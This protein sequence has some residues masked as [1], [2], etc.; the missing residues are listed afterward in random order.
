MHGMKAVLQ[1]AYSVTYNTTK[2][3]TSD[4]FRFSSIYRCN[5]VDERLRRLINEIGNN[6]LTVGKLRTSL[7][8]SI[9]SHIEMEYIY[10][11]L[12]M[13][14]TYTLHTHIHRCER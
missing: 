12:Y 3:K 10:R 7:T 5:T 8:S 1:T 4:S 14:V 9:A 6:I 13:Y 2:V 11:R